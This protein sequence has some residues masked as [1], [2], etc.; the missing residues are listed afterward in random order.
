M[1]TDRWPTANRFVKRLTKFKATT[2]DFATLVVEAT[3]EKKRR[4]LR[5]RGPWEL[6]IRRGIAWGIN[7]SLFAT[8]LSLAMI[9]AAKFGEVQ[10]QRMIISWLIAYGWTFAIVEPAQ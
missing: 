5:W 1:G 6:T 3:L 4:D 2:K 9:Y 10:T 7:L 8:C